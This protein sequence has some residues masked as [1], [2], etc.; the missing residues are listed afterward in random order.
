MQKLIYSIIIAITLSSSCKS[1]EKMSQPDVATADTILLASIERTPCF[2]QCPTYKI[3]IY[4]SGYV[5]Y[6]GKQHVK[7]IG[8]FSLRL[9]KS[10][11]E[12]IKNF[13]LQNK[14]LE[15]NDEYK[16]PRI[17]DYPS[18]LTEANLNGKY[19]HIIETDPQAPKE[20]KDFQKFLDSFFTDETNWTPLNKEMK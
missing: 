14:I 4:Q 3:S 19:K 12:E 16:N 10:K 20:I 13:I 5:V 7:N 11:V 1:K 15:M 9:D 6:E 8:F 17:A 2:G 18:T